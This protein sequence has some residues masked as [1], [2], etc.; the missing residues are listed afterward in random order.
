MG[1]NDIRTAIW[2]AFS[3]KPG[4]NLNHNDAEESM[5]N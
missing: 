3:S 1:G 2:N 4:K 5:S